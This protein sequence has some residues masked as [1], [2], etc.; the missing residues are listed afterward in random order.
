VSEKETAVPGP[1]IALIIERLREK[2]PDAKYELNWT[3]P[4]EL[5]VATTLAAQCT[6]ERVNRITEALFKKY[7]S[8][9]A[10][11]DV[12]AEELENDIRASGTYKQKAK[13]IRGACQ[14][15]VDRFDGEVPRTMDELTTL[16]GIAR[17]SAN[18]VLNTAFD[19]A[20]GI[21]VDTHVARV[22]PRLGLTRQT[23]PEDIER[24]LMRLVPQNE[25][26]FFGPAMVLHGRY[27]CVARGPKCGE[28]IFE[29]VCEKRGV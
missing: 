9:Q 15:I 26:T 27:T 3:T 16:P 8:A 10:F 25:W 12:P 19:I 4:L 6:D 11:L 14:A 17:K 21:I 13:S 7:T 28:C 20:S 22:S 29:D 1:D 5:L 2:H 18:V 24:D 23:K